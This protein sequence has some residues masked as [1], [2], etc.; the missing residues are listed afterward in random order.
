[1]CITIDYSKLMYLPYMSL[2][3]KEFAGAELLEM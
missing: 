2:K 1:M 3:S